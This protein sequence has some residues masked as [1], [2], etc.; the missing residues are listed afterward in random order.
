M[1]S[2]NSPRIRL[3]GFTLIELLVVIAI[4]AVLIA[5]LL[6]AVQAAGGGCSTAQSTNNLKQLGLAAQNYAS[7]I[8]GFP[9]A[10]Q[11]MYDP[12]AYPG[13]VQ[14][15][16]FPCQSVF[17]SML[18]QFEQQ[19]LFNAM[20]FSRSIYVAE[21]QTIYM[22]G[23]AAYR[24]PRRRDDHET[25]QF[26]AGE[27][28]RRTSR[29]I[30]QAT[31]LASGPTTPSPPTGAAESTRRSTLCRRHRELQRNVCTQPVRQLLRHAG[32]HQQYDH[33]WRAPPTE[34]SRLTTRRTAGFGGATD[35]RPI[36]CLKQCT[37]STHSISCKTS[38]RAG[39]W[40][41]WVR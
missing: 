2:P 36:L 29:F 27:G 31:A 22:T 7:A 25:G 24:V 18:G 39:P 8:G 9:M 10:S 16:N 14:Y 35:T 26:R 32:R 15:A 23:L 12:V 38:R 5:L 40:A 1:K 3:R 28:T 19:P 33:F 30:S 37:Q 11:L 20:N 6:P 41:I 17:V 21:N 34:D 4:I 13:I